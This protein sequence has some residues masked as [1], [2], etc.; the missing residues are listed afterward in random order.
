MQKPFSS[1]PGSSLHSGLHDVDEE[2]DSIERFPQ[3]LSLRFPSLLFSAGLM[4]HGLKRLGEVQLLRASTT[5]KDE[6]DTCFAALVGMLESFVAMF[7]E[8]RNVAVR[9]NSIDLFLSALLQ[10][11]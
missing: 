6:I 2:D 3:R 10:F 1:D 7:S 5:G 9:G 4:E 11:A 8:A